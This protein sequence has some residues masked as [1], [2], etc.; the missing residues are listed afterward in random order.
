M[1]DELV[2]EHERDIKDHSQRLTWLITTIQREYEHTPELE[3][4]L[5]VHGAL[6]PTT[7]RGSF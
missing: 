6:L 4:H 7:H 5:S 1:P 3:R 2:D